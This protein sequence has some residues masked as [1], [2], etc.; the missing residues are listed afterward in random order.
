MG[1]PP[2][3]DEAEDW[4]TISTELALAKTP[5]DDVLEAPVNELSGDINIVI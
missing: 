2:V 4:A 5:D 3:E 1:L